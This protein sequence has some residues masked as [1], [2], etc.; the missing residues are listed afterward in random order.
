MAA[1][2]A[3]YRA[4]SRPESLILVASPTDRQ[5]GEFLR[6]AAGMVQKLGI[7]PCGDGDNDA[8]LIFPNGSRIVGL[9]GMEDTVRVF[10]AVSLMLI[11]EAARVS[12]TSAF[13]NIT[14]PG[15]PGR[16]IEVGPTTKIFTKPDDSRTEDYITGRF[17]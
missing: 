15:E 12:D 10:S 13:F 1:A 7:A 11:D 3:V 17:G 8:S 9:P 16:L 2:K 6:K 4:W 14:G 5:S